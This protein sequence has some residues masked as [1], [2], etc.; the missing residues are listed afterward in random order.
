MTSSEMLR[1]EIDDSGMTITSIA[2][3]AGMSR[4]TLYNK[5]DKVESFTASEIVALS[6]ILHLSKDKRDKIFLN[7]KLN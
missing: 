1:K 5:L 7:Q 2:S 3:K 6:S 4:G